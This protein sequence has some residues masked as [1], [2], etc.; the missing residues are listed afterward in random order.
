MA[1][2][3]HIAFFNTVVYKEAG[4]YRMVEDFNTYIYSY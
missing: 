2:L 4:L 3:C 1:K